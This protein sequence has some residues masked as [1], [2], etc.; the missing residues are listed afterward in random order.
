MRRCLGE[1]QGWS[2]QPVPKRGPW[3][4]GAAGSLSGQGAGT[5]VGS[6]LLRHKGAPQVVLEKSKKEKCKLEYNPLQGEAAGQAG[7]WCAL[8][9]GREGQRERQG[10]T[11][12]GKNT[13]L[14]ADVNEDVGGK[15]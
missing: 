15:R 9:F 13:A 8:G 14:E 4:R 6:W 10:S 2:P 3:A 11:T 1:H 12:G 7:Q 5:A